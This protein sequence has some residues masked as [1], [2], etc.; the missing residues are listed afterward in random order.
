ME[1]SQQKYKHCYFR[2]PIADHDVVFKANKVKLTVR[3]ALGVS[4]TCKSLGCVMTVPTAS[5]L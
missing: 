3:F 4:A 5:R 1:I 2:N